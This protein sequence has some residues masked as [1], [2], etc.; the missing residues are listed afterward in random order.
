[1][2]KR[3]IVPLIILDTML[4]AASA[5]VMFQRYGALAEELRQDT[6]EE[7][8]PEPAPASYTSS[9]PLPAVSSAPAAAQEALSPSPAPATT[10]NIAFV[11]Y[12]S[13]AGRVMI[14]G[15]FT[16][17]K[18]VPMKK[19]KGNRWAISIPLRPGTYAYNFVVDGKTIRDPS[20]RR[21][22]SSGRGFCS[23]SLIVEQ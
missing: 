13:R 12:N 22:C 14:M 15:E 10:R 9:T 21:S 23:S 11:L 6:I 7:N 4:I 3:K 17:W 5:A 16:G 2:N 19:R 18:R 20:N 8:I 1:M